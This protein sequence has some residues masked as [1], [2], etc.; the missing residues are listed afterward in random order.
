MVTS[1]F[2]I[3]ILSIYRRCTEIKRHFWNPAIKL[4]QKHFYF[5]RK[6][7]FEYLTSCDPRLNWPFSVVDSHGVKLQC[8]IDFGILRA[9]VTMNFAAWPIFFVLSWPDPDP[10]PYLVWHLCSHNIFT[11][12]LR[13]GCGVRVGVG[14]AR[15][16]GNESGVGFG[17]GVDQTASTPTPERFL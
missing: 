9:K 15:S 10:V 12:P 17:V 11:S 13:Q 1:F 8:R 2:Q 16:R 4:V 7:Q 5:I 6:Y 14:V 3:A